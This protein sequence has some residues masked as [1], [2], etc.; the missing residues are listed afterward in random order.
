M[1][2]IPAEHARDV[3]EALHIVVSDPGLGPATLSNAP[4]MSNLLKDLLP[5]APREK[6]LLVAAADASLA[7]LMLDYA[8]QGVDGGSAIRLA[9][10]SFGANTHFTGSVCTWVATELAVALELVPA[11]S[12][13]QS[14]LPEEDVAAPEPTPAEPATPQTVHAPTRL[15][16]DVGGGKADGEDGEDTLRQAATER[17]GTAE[18]DSRTAPHD[19][20]RP[21]PAVAGT[22]R[23][24]VGLG[25]ALV[26]VGF[27]GSL[28]AYLIPV[29]YDSY[30]G[31]VRIWGTGLPSYV[32]DLGTIF[33]V[34]V[35][36]CVAATTLARAG[37]I[38]VATGGALI[39]CGLAMI[40]M[41]AII[42]WRSVRINGEQ[43]GAGISTGV[44]SAALLVAG[45]LH[46]LLRGRVTVRPELR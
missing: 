41:F 31:G 2:G 9:A 11:T 26:L 38:R 10:A 14:V 3:R 5:D 29:Y 8:A 30:Y 23:R 7:N 12:Y 16:T 25:A 27:V 40:V 37:R 44:V 19:A 46:T 28:V 13:A 32:T 21:A 43:L 18:H 36:P 20:V 35:V 42:Y 4:A 39:A 45:G 22:R 6:N 15:A 17:P 24:G 34:L 1:A 33:V